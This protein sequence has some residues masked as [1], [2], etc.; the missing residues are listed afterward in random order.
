MLGAGLDGV[1]ARIKH[2]LRL[3][4]NRPDHHRSRRHLLPGRGIAFAAD[5]ETAVFRHR[6]QAVGGEVAQ[7]A[8]TK[9]PDT[10][11]FG[12]LT[13][14]VFRLDGEAFLTEIEAR[15]VLFVL[16]AGARCNLVVSGSKIGGEPAD[17]AVTVE[18]FGLDTQAIEG[19][20]KRADVIE[21]FLRRRL[22]LPLP[23]GLALKA[24]DAD[25]DFLRGN[26]PAFFLGDARV[27][28]CTQFVRQEVAVFA[29]EAHH[30]QRQFVLAQ[31]LRQAGMEVVA[32]V[33]DVGVLQV[34]LDDI[35]VVRIVFFLR[36]LR[37]RLC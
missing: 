2:H 7:V 13:L 5:T 9:F 26:A 3:R 18:R 25:V 16:V 20:K 34:N 11:L 10:A 21:Q 33:V 14:P 23:V 1:N 36:Q 15:Q 8:V 32:K 37:Q 29:Q 6:L 17:E 22:A 19:T 35:G 4:R 28:E 12:F 27:L 30:V 31:M 24:V